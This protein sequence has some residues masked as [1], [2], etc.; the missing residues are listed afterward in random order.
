MF[1][2]DQD[3]EGQSSRDSLQFRAVAWH[4]KLN[5]ERALADYDEAIRLNPNYANAV[6]N[7]GIAWQAT[8]SLDMRMAGK[9]YLLPVDSKIENSAAVASEV[10]DLSEP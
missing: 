7:R 6:N 3:R 5:F 2:R 1:V 8:G 10:V 4:D 9:N